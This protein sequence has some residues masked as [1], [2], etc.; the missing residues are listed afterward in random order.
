MAEFPNGEVY[1][2]NDIAPSVYTARLY[3]KQI[4]PLSTFTNK[5]NDDINQLSTFIPTSYFSISVG[6]FSIMDFFDNNKFSHDPRTQFYNWALM[7]NGAWNYPAN[8]RGYT[9]GLVT[10]LVK[11]KWAL[12]FSTVMVPIAANGPVMD[13]NILRSHSETLEFEHKYSFGQQSGTIK[14]MTFITEARMGNYTKAINW[15]IEHRSIP[16]IDSTHA[17]GRTKFGV[18]INV[19]QNISNCI[20]LFFRTSWNDGKNETWAFT[21]IDKAISIGMQLDGKIWNCNHDK[22]GLAILANGLSNAHRDY[23]KA[24]GYGFII[25]DGRLSYKPEMISELYYSLKLRGYPFWLSP[26]YQ[27]IINPAYNKDRD[28][29]HAFG[30]RA[31]MEF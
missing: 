28:S 25:G 10:E 15:S 6:K 11:P 16:I 13:K 4:F 18:G 31:H 24:G 19:E 30:I 14:F 1:R 26:D 2:V 3:L 17:T 22:I 7:G 8:T 9:Y 21:E 12:R 27:F 5:V 29:V 20:G 23:L